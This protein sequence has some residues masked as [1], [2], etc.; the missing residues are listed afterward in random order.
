MVHVIGIDSL[1]CKIKVL[2]FVCASEIVLEGHIFI[3]IF[4]YD[5]LAEKTRTFFK[6]IKNPLQ[7]KDQHI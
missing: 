5:T 6:H 3:I 7:I 1:N 4:N 2:T